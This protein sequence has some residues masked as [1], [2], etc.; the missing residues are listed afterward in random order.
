[1]SDIANTAHDLDAQDLLVLAGP[2]DG[3]AS[4]PGASRNARLPFP[5]PRHVVLVIDPARARSIHRDIAARLVREAGIGVSVRYARTPD[6]LPSSVGL[7]LA[8][9]KLLSGSGATRPSDPL[10]VAQLSVPARAENDRPDI[11]IDFCG[12]HAGGRTIQVLYD[13]LP[14]E[15]ALIGAL[16]SGRM[17]TIEIANGE[18]RSILARG[19]ACADNAGT[20]LD[21]FDC[22]LARVTDLVIAVLRGQ[23]TLAPARAPTQRIARL[24][25]V[26][27][28]EAK[29]VAH[30]AVR[31]LYH[32]CCYAP[33]WRTCWRF[34]DGPDLWETGTT[35]GTSWNVIPDPGFRFYADPCPFVHRG[36]TWVFVEDF[37]HRSNKGVISVVPFDER[38][39][40]GPAQV[41]IEES[42]HLSYPF[43]FAH[44]GQVWMI[45]ESTANRSITLYRAEMF[46]HRWVKETTLV[47]DIEASDATLVH[48]DGQFWMFA[49]TRGGG[50]GSWSDTLSIFS[51]P[52]LRG[53]WVPH[54]GNPVLVD[55]TSAR[56]AG[57]FVK[58]NGKL[59]RPVQDC[60]RGYGTGIGL[61]EVVRLDGEAYE[62]KVHAVLR[63]DPSWPG[64]RLHTLNRAGRLECI[65][66]AAHSPRNR[67]LA[68]RLANWSGR[69]EAPPEMPHPK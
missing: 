3:A 25:D 31:R 55:Q 26:A 22:V 29:T 61:A 62:Q 12:S 16:L 66:G 59:W 37:D 58:R 49:A 13:G 40:A 1:V 46:P 64:R 2:T 41:V 42:W 32:L 30:A 33:H 34:V 23:A 27:A 57:C 15:A 5:L 53:P 7:L 48:H 56:P 68:Q 21:A 4:V 44:G 18:D 67:W 28:F 11:T 43:V 51:A 69:R 9:E 63:A 45:P 54:R 50:L 65:D 52:A 20:V 17:P 60:S 36:R 19:V 24:R 6:T 8:L 38:G 39:P 14:S 47:A 10:D 35:A